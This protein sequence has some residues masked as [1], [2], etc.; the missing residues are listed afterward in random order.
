LAK[1][2]SRSAYFMLVGALTLGLGVCFD[3]VRLQLWC[4]YR[5]AVST[6]VRVPHQ[7]G[8][9]NGKLSTTLT[10]TH[11]VPAFF[12]ECESQLCTHAGDLVAHLLRAVGARADLDLGSDAWHAHLV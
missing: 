10:P 2:R 6:P 1:G 3:T 5:R 11:S 7:H 4:K 8:V 12:R 9:R